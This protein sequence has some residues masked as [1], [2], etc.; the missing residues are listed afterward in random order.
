MSQRMGREGGTTGDGEVSHDTGGQGNAQA[1]DEGVGHEWSGQCVQPF[2]IIRKVDGAHVP[3]FSPC[4]SCSP[5]TGCGSASLMLSILGAVG[6]T[7]I[8]GVAV[9]VMVQ[10]RHF[11]CR[12]HILRLVLGLIRRRGHEH[13]TLRS[14][15]HLHLCAVEVGE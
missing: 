5:L 1:G 12:V 15:D 10:L 11:G 14:G 7:A 2:G 6:G 3:V 9:L 13:V 8:G 4:L